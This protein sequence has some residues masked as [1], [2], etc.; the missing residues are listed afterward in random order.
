MT[1]ALAW[2]PSVAVLAAA[3]ILGWLAAREVS[4][5]LAVP[6]VIISAV[7]M[8]IASRNVG[9][10]YS[11]FRRVDD[12]VWFKWCR[13]GLIGPHRMM[14]RRLPANPR[15]RVCLVPFGGV[16][17]MLRISPSH[18][19]PNFC[20]S[21][22]ES[23]PLG[24]HEMDVGVLFADIRG[25]TAWSETHSSDDAAGAIAQFYELADVLVRDDALVE[26]IGDQIMALYLPD[27]PSLGERTAL[28]MVEA[29]NRLLGEMSDEQREEPLPLGVGIHMGRASV[30]NVGTGNLKT[31]TAVG[32]VVNTAARLQSCAAGGE[33]LV[34]DIVYA[35]VAELYP[36]A[37]PRSLS[38]KG[39]SEPVDVHVLRS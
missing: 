37:E 5:A 38:L 31:F 29:A 18:M 11:V 2:A 21:C 30:G 19:N 27:F 32:D 39:K 35:K 16:G 25:Y 24:A 36:N 1:T 34:S 6:V 15:C 26:L 3:L 20:R 9:A 33:I 13:R 10:P 17:K 7:G 4:S 14:Y 8:W 12:Q 28:V 22:L 23:A